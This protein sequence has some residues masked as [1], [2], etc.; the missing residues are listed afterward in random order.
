[1]ASGRLAETLI[2]KGG[3]SQL[4]YYWFDQRGRILTIEIVVKWY[5]FQ[6]ALFKNRSDGALVRVSMPIAAV[7]NDSIARADKLLDKFIVTAQP[8]LQQYLPY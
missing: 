8:V 7:D 4:V 2:Q 1:M 3:N 6:D 5:L